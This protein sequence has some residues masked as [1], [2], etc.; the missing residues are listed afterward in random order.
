MFDKFYAAGKNTA[1]L[2]TDKPLTPGSYIVKIGD[3]KS[4]KQRLMT[5]I[6][7]P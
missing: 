4:I 6:R 3:G 7:E 1:Y 5:I 2:K